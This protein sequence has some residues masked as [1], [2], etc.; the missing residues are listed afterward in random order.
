MPAAEAA[1]DP[2]GAWPCWTAFAAPLGDL[3][4]GAPVREPRSLRFG[5]AAI[6]QSALVSA[7]TGKVVR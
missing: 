2:A 5:Q 3:D 7:E 4:E 1:K 6:G